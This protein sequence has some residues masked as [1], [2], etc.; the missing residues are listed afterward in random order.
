MPQTIHKTLGYQ[1]N[2]WT[3]NEKNKL[4]VDVLIVDES[5]MVD[6]DLMGRV[7]DALKPT[8]ALVLVG[9]HNQLPPVGPGAVLQDVI[10]G[11]LCRVI[12]L[13]TVIRQAGVLKKNATELLR[14]VMNPTSRDENLGMDTWVVE[15]HHINPQSAHDAIAEHYRQRLT[16]LGQRGLLE[17]QVISPQYDKTVGIDALNKTL[18]KIAH[19]I[20]YHDTIDP[21][22]AIGVN[23]KVIQTK[24]DYQVGI[25]NG[26]QG[27]VVSTDGF[28]NEFGKWEPGWT[29]SMQRGGDREDVQVPIARVTGFMLAYAISCHRYQGSESEYVI[30]AVHSEHSYML[31]RKL[32]Y[33][34]ATRA[35]RALVLI[36]D[37]KGLHDGTRKDDTS[38]RRTL[39]APRWL[40]DRLA[41]DPGV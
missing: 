3:Y 16:E 30:G 5:S 28:V 19:E 35:S 13:E 20:L 26:D 27:V 2:K 6:L 7:I 21:A 1:G 29:V 41:Q 18:R 4:P 8:T 31:N 17:I 12:R 40:L 14:G 39:S 37:R 23:D 34:M 9:D 11:E 33:T 32:I 24:N 25:M 22:R 36:G 10:E 15:D 38:Y